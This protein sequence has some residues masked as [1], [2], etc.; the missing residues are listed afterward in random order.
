MN[1]SQD[2]KKRPAQASSPRSLS[3]QITGAALFRMALRVTNS[4][5]S[6][7]QRATVIQ[8]ARRVLS[9]QK[10]CAL[11]RIVRGLVQDQLNIKDQ[12]N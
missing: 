12:R 2:K 8:S 9:R 5:F 11:E 6:I 4:N 1:T 3:D 7:A 10:Y